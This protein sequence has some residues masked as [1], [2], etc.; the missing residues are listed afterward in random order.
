MKGLIEAMKSDD[1]R[2]DASRDRCLLAGSRGQMPER[3]GRGRLKEVVGQTRLAMLS[4]SSG[5][6]GRAVG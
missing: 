6:L 5:S 4:A 2:Q 3:P 1:E